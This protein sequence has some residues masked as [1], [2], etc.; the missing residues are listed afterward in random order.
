LIF[1]KHA[2]INGDI[3]FQN[4]T[5]MKFDFSDSRMETDLNS[6]ISENFKN[7][8]NLRVG[9]EY[10]INQQLSLRGGYEYYGNPYKNSVNEYQP[11]LES[12]SMFACGIGYNIGK[13]FTD[14]AYRKMISNYKLNEIQP[15]F[16]D[17]SLNNNANKILFTMG[18]KF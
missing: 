12:Y 4:Y 6:S 5:T 14:I 10:K 11:V 15:N 16:E 3:E 9:G 8:F 1:G 2:A 18:F 13:F 7:V 17:V